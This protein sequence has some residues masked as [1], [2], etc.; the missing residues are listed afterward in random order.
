MK[1]YHYILCL[2][3]LSLITACEEE[4]E[5]DFPDYVSDGIVFKGLI[6]NENPPYF[7]D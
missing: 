2:S 3:L 5:M 6:T 4:F 1:K 7:S